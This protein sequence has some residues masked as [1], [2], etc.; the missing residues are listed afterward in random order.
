MNANALMHHKTT[1]IEHVHDHVASAMPTRYISVSKDEPRHR[2]LI[3]SVKT[4]EGKM[5]E[6]STFLDPRYENGH[7]C[8]HAQVRFTMSWFGHF[9]TQWKISRAY[10]QVQYIRKCYVFYLEFA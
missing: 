2:P 10:T 6:E 3:L 1:R 5:G 7:G 9:Q 4:F 8:C